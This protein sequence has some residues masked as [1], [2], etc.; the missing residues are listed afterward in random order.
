PI[1]AQKIL[2]KATTAARAREAAKKARDLVLRKNAMDGGSLPGTLADCSEKDPAKSELYI[3]EGPSAGGSAKQGRDRWFQA[4]LP[5][6]GKILNVEKARF[7]RMIESETIRMLITALGCGIGED[8]NQSKLRYH[9]VVIMTDADVDGAHIRTLLLTFFF[10]NLPELITSGYLYIAQ[11]PL[12]RASR[13]RS[14]SWLFSDDELDKWLASRV[15]S[16]LS[17]TSQTDDQVSFRGGPL[18]GI[19]SPV[20]DF[21]VAVAALRTLGVSEAVTLRLLSDPDLQHL[22]FRPPAPDPVQPTMF[23]DDA[24]TDGTGPDSES[25]VDITAEPIETPPPAPDITFDIDGYTLTRAIYEHPVMNTA[26]RL[27][28]K[29]QKIVENSP[30][31]IAREEDEIARDVLWSDLV[32]TL[33]ENADRGNVSIQRY[34]GLGEMNADQLW[35]TTMDPAERVML[36]VTADDLIQ[37]DELFRTLMGDDVGPRRDFIRTHALEVRNLD[38]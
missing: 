19:L 29:V 28:P 7:E 4:V 13:G 20:R 32:T 37:A 22:D 38:I 23:A 16:K 5:L 8:Y 9:R 30:Y 14:A 2:E 15:Y 34:K 21:G 24:S 11:A 36:R 35:E 26:R 31:G 25:G 1:D 12:Y 3:V 10:R 33:E 6:R 18:G 27:Y 17:V